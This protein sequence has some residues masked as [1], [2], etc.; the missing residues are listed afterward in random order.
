[1]R[2]EKRRTLSTRRLAEGCIAAS[3]AATAAAA[4]APAAQASTR[5]LI[6]DNYYAPN[7]N[8]CSGPG[9]GYDALE[10]AHAQARG[11][12]GGGGSGY[13]CADI[14]WANDFSNGYEGLHCVAQKGAIATTGHFE[15]SEFTSTLHT[16]G[17]VR[18]D[19]WDNRSHLLVMYSYWG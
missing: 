9:R 12:I 10:S 1:M 16:H 5:D 6:C 18:G 11:S 4:L 7:Q 8:G 13:A 3:L 19:G 15:T 2:R 17:W 14:L